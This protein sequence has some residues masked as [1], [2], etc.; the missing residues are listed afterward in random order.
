MTKLTEE[1]RKIADLDGYSVSNLGKV[2]NDKTGRILKTYD[3]GKGYEKV[4]IKNRKW[5]VHRLVGSAFIPNPE[6]LETINHKNRVKNDN[7]VENLEWMSRADNLR[8]SVEKPIEQYDLETGELVAT[9][10]SLSKCCEVTGYGIDTVSMAC[11]G[12]Y[13]KAYGYIWKHGNKPINE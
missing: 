6:N 1:W 7:R 13:K 2:R 9:Y 10:P 3:S 12:K 11:N 8:Y 4:E 5:F